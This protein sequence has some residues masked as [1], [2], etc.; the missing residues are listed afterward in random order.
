MLEIAVFL[1]FLVS[2][3]VSMRELSK[4]F[5]PESGYDEHYTETLYSAVSGPDDPAEHDAETQ[6]G[7]RRTRNRRAA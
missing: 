5:A 2:F 4:S 6:P 3:A 7:A 1:L